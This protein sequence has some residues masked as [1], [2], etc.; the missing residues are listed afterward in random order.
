MKS[1]GRRPLDFIRI[2]LSFSSSPDFSTKNVRI[3][4]KYVSIW[5]HGGDHSKWSNFP[6]WLAP[7]VPGPRRR[8]RL[9]SRPTAF[10]C[11][12][13]GTF[14]IPA[15]CPIAKNPMSEQGLVGGRTPLAEHGGQAQGGG[16]GLPCLLRCLNRLRFLL[17]L[18]CPSQ[19]A[20]FRQN[21]STLASTRHAAIAQDSDL[22][23][24]GG[25]AVS[26]CGCNASCFKPT[27]R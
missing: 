5:C 1:R 23:S 26:C 9:W 15:L 2:I 25:A 6:C 11:Q 13:L 8:V 17:V 10:F 12:G 3:C 16:S 19:A 7:A 14:T 21:P 27:V 20:K 22:D 24:L 18:F 4:D